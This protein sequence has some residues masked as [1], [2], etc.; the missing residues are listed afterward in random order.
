MTPGPERLVG[1]W[2]L[3]KWRIEYGDGRV[4]HPFGADARGRLLYQ[5]GGRMCATVSAA[6]R[7]GLG[8]A[9]ARH[10]SVA[11]KAAAFD[12][13]FH[14][15]GTWRLEGDV[16]VHAVEFAL[17]P[18]MIGTEQRRSATF[19][20]PDRLTLSADE[21]QDKKRM[22]RHVLTWERCGD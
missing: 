22:R 18:D 1:A 7:P 19:D 5:A 8:H 17:N 21:R 14:Y 9:N 11:R 10:A 4:T 13:Y 16:V 12:T 3:A 20:G 2:S 15:A 6:T